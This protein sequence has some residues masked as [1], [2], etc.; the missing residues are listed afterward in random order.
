[1]CKTIGLRS[2]SSFGT[3][4]RTLPKDVSVTMF[5]SFS[6][7]LLHFRSSPLDRGFWDWRLRDYL[8]PDNPAT[9]LPSKDIEVM[10]E[11]VDMNKASEV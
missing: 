3:I 4:V 5:K 6:D 11:S 10:F 7:G 8:D 9:N 2:S 1:M